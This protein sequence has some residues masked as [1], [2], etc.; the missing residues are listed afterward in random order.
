M[1][2]KSEK[3]KA[4]GTTSAVAESVTIFFKL[5]WANIKKIEVI[6]IIMLSIK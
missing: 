3:Q 5:S 4:S 6:V 2:R 1:D